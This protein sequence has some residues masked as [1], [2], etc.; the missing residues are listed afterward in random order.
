MEYS[1]LNTKNY[2]ASVQKLRDGFTSRFPKFRRDEIKVKLFAHLLDLAVEDSPG[3]CQ[4]ELIELQADM[5]TKSG[6]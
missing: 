2:A 6:N 1:D 4:M 3:D 5:D